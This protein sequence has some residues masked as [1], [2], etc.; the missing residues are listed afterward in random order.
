MTSIQRLDRADAVRRLVDRDGSLF[1]DDPTIQRGV[2]AAEGW[3]GL[4]SGDGRV[5]RDVRALAAELEAE[6][7]TDAVLLGMGGSSLASIVLDRAL[8]PTLATRGMSLHVLD[9]TSPET[10]AGVMERIDPARAVV[11]V[12]SKSGGTIEPLSL[13][14]IFRAA[15]DGMLGSAQAGRRFVALTDPGSELERLAGQS[16]FRS[17]INTPADVG[18][19]YSALTAFHLLPAA[20]L[21]LD[22]DE[23]LRRAQV[24][25]DATIASACDSPAAGLAA[26]MADAADEGRD[27][28]VI[29]TSPG[30]ESFGLWVEQLIAESLGKEG[31]GIVPVPAQ[32]AES[33]ADAGLDRAVV[34]LRFEDDE[35]TRRR[36]S[37]LA[38]LTDAP[39]ADIVL[40]DAY[41]LAAEFVRWEYAVALTGYLLGIDPFDQ[42]DVAVAKEATAAIL[43]GGLPG[44]VPIAASPEGAEFAVSELVL[45]DD[46]PLGLEAALRATLAAVDEDDY[47]A[48]LAYLPERDEL[49]DPL[50]EG[51]AAAGA[52]TG[53]ATMLELGPRYL[54]STG[55]L[56]KGGPETGVFI[57]VSGR[58]GPDIAV[59]GREFTLRDLH[60]AQA[61]GDFTTLTRR[62]RRALWVSLPDTSRTS[63]EALATALALAASEA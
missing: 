32:D 60:A 57:V 51:L 22:P 42:P 7:V 47:L 2:T 13:Y 35:A 17:V 29:V 6:H 15:F 37:E 62:G 28:L 11:L 12:S 43:S 21:G 25:E 31:T 58:E 16:G 39:V 33:L 55:Q 53:A 44:P 48:M 54:H 8:A 10:V 61:A 52:A 63:V 9:T 5:V 41:D 27:K 3:I 4:S 23:I 14:A 45:P 18:G 36:V 49:L 26:F 59:P 30:L 56:H 20:L 50:A 46:D 1:S 38:A 34:M 40:G 24:M 19:R